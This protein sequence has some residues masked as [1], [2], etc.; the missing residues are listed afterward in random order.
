[1]KIK[2]DMKIIRLYRMRI[3]YDKMNVKYYQMNIELYKMRIKQD[4]MNKN[5]LANQI[6][7][8]TLTRK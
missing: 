4:K 5:K 6:D 8:L 1:M 2:R 7:H 3:K